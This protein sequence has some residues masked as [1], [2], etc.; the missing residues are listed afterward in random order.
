V[1]KKTAPGFAARSYGDNRHSSQW[2]FYARHFLSQ[3]FCDYLLWRGYLG[4]RKAG[5]AIRGTANPSSHAAIPGGFIHI[6]NEV[7]P[8]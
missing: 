8:P 5:R 6:L 7:L 4:S 3:L 1:L 2:L